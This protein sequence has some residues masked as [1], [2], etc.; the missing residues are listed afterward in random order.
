MWKFFF[1]SHVF[2]YIQTTRLQ[3]FHLKSF[4]W[5]YIKN[6]NHRSYLGNKEKKAMFLVVFLIRCALWFCVSEFWFPNWV[7]KAQKIGHDELTLSMSGF[8]HCI[9]VIFQCANYKWYEKWFIYYYNNIFERTDLRFRFNFYTV[10]KMRTNLM[11]LL[12]SFII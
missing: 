2:L 6:E 3:K 4:P 5:K 10:M 9:K 8:L 11:V 12:R 7:H 1:E